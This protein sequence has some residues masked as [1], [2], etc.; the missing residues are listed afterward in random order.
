MMIGISIP[1]GFHTLVFQFK[2]KISDTERR[3]LCF[4]CFEKGKILNIFISYSQKV[5]E[6]GARRKI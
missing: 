4:I 2:Q 1:V 6:K 5:S 3:R